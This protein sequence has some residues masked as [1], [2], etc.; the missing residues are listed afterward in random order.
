MDAGV[1]TASDAAIAPPAGAGRLAK[2]AGKTLAIGVGINT[3]EM[4][5]GNIGS[6]TIMSYTV[7]G[8]AVNLGSRLES[9]NEDLAR[10]ASERI[11]EE[12]EIH[13]ADRT[14]PDADRKNPH[15]ARAHLYRRVPI[16]QRCLH[17]READGAH[18]IEQ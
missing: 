3:G 12:A 14:G 6:E 7:I 15:Q 13:E 11:G 16:D 4:V 9:L 18:A 2:T 1:G 10:A 17:D 5:A 8:D